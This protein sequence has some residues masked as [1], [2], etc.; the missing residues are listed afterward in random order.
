MS[1]DIVRLVA[2]K[3]VDDMLRLEPF[4]DGIDDLE[5]LQEF[6]DGLHPFARM[7]A[8]VALAAILRLVF[9]S[10]IVQEE[11]ATTDGSL[12]I[13][14]RFLQELSSDILL[15]N[16]L[17]LHELL[18]LAQVVRREESEAN[19]FAAISS[20]PTGFLIVTFQ[21][22]RNVVMDDVTHIWLVDTHAES[23][24]SNDDIDALHEEIV[25]SLSPICRFHA[26]MIGSSRNVVGTQHLGQFLNSATAQTVDDSALALVLQD[27]SR[28]VFINILRLRTDFVVEVGA[29]ER[30]LELRSIRNTEVLLDVRSHFICGCCGQGNNGSDAYLVHKRPDIAVFR[31]EVMSPFGYTMCL[32]DSI[33]RDL[34][35]LK[36]ANVLLFGQRLRRHIKEFRATIADVFLCRINLCL[37]ERR[38]EIVGDAVVVSQLTYGIHL[39]LHECNERRHNDGCA[40]AD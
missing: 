6:A 12:G 17:S 33:E 8:V 20:C 9:L 11:L 3:D 38:V 25:L 13:S 35:A 10:E 18:Q 30:A 21:A 1:N 5:H 28:D 36:E 34:R 24:G 15:C 32:I 19:T 7:Q 26:G 40:F 27:K 16:R 22:F 31:T 23:N 39:I 4:L 2:N 29:I 14:S 37:R